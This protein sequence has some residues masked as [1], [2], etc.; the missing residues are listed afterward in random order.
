MVTVSVVIPTFNHQTF[1]S[2]AVESAL[3]QTLRPLEVIVVD[4]GSTDATVE[5]LAPYLSRI[6]LVRQPNQGVSAA[7]NVGAGRATGEVLAFLDADDLWLPGKLERQVQRLRSDPGLGL[8]HCGMEEVDG[9]GNPLRERLDGM[10]GWVA[11][12]LL[13]FRQS[14]ILG[15]GSSALIRRDVFQQVGGFDSRLSTSADWDLCYRIASRWE[16]G[17]VREVL[18]R[19]RLHGANMH[20][21]IVRM[22]HDMLLAYAKAFSDPDDSHRRLRRS[23]YGNLHAVLAGSYFSVGRYADFARHMLMSLA[24]T[25][26]NIGRFLGYPVRRLRRRAAVSEGISEFST[27]GVGR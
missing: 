25:P 9:Q 3:A 12:E 11:P 10:E 22:E 26:G 7:R 6:R 8:V 13:L 16:V 4:D 20:G 27:Q 23:S 18:F 17:F 2:A 14:V 1:I 21:N 19:Y 24:L 15:A 5:I